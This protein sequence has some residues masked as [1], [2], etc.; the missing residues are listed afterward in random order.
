MILLDTYAVSAAQVLQPGQEDRD[1]IM[2]EMAA[3]M[4]EHESE[5]GPFDRTK[6]TA[7]ARYM[8]VL[9]QV[10]V[11]EIGA[12]TLLLRPERRFGI[13]AGRTGPD[14]AAAP[15]GDWRTTWDRM[16]DTRTIAGDHFSL[17]EDSS[18][19]TAQAVEDWLGSLL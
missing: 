15:D 1:Q 11:T 7:M 13:T 9:P 18:E 19:T 8:S 12:P 14:G 5:Y 3:G 6:L 16:D 4:L 10:Q 17:V 2:A